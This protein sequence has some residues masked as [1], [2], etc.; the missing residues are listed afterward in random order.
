MQILRT[1]AMRVTSGISVQTTVTYEGNECQSVN[2]ELGFWQI[3]AKSKDN[4]IV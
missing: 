2:L 4:D 1:A 3:S